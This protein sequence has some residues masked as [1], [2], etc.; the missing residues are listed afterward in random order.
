MA[1]LRIILNV[2][3][4][5]RGICRSNSSDVRLLFV[6]L[7]AGESSHCSSFS[8]AAGREVVS[9]GVSGCNAETQQHRPVSKQLDNLLVAFA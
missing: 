6:T 3:L 5:L 1:D 8:V 9:V 7:V 4:Q 2:G